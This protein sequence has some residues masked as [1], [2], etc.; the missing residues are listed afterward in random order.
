MTQEQIELAINGIKTTYEERHRHT[1]VAIN[2]LHDKVAAMCAVL[3][4]IA[5]KGSDGA[6]AIA[7]FEKIEQEIARIRIG[8]AGIAP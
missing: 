4:R 5:P 7:D 6:K 1:V 2:A 8:R 3:A